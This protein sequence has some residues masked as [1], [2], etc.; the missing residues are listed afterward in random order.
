MNSP[1][2][3]IGLQLNFVY[4]ST[5]AALTLIIFRNVKKIP[6]FFLQEISFSRMVLNLWKYSICQN[7]K[8]QNN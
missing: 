3:P 6:I 1:V 5:L 4:H 7:E 8:N 2:R